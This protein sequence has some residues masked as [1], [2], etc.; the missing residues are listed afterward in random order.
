MANSFT[1]AKG[2]CDSTSFL[3][4]GGDGLKPMNGRNDR[5]VSLGK[6]AVLSDM[7]LIPS[8]PNVLYV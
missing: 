2:N 7:N 3:L 8:M 5:S 1:I 4:S 6:R